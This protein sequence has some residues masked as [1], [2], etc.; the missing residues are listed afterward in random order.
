MALKANLISA[1]AFESAARNPHDPNHLMVIKP[2]KQRVRVFHGDCLLA[3][4]HSAK[5][6]LEVGHGVYDPVIYIPVKDIVFD[7][8]PVE[9][10]T[11]CPIKG[12]ARYVAAH[13]E[14]VGWVYDTPLPMATELGECY[15]FW[16]DKTRLVIGM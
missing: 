12:D 11:H 8:T 9:K 7:F 15:A 1:P 5:R 13:G 4:S 16:P 10:S 6:V 3:D 2:V 14:E